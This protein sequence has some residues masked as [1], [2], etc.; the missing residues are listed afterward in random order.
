MGKNGTKYEFPLVLKAEKDIEFASLLDQELW[1]K[2]EIEELRD[3]YGARVFY[4]ALYWARAMQYFIKQGESIA[5][6]AVKSWTIARIDKITENQFCEAL[7]FLL[8]TWKYKFEL[9]DWVSKYEHLGIGFLDHISD[10]RFLIGQEGS[11]IVREML[12]IAKLTKTRISTYVLDIWYSVWPEMSEDDALDHLEY[13][14]KFR[15]HHEK[16]GFV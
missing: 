1:H 5:D 10:V 6:C 2:I 11:H 14:F 9:L 15:A 7:D 12:E 13:L 16:V 3:P 4:F 8:V